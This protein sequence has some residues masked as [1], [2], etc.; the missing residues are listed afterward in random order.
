[1]RFK[2]SKDILSDF[3]LFH[4]SLYY[5]VQ[6]EESKSMF[7]NKNGTELLFSYY[8]LLDILI[9]DTKEFLNFKTNSSASR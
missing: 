4:E 6:P 7:W 9:L 1:M 8:H 3:T 5:Y 2:H